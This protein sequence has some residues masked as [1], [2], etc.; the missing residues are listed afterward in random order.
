MIGTGFRHLPGVAT[1]KLDTVRCNGCR[2]CTEVCPHGVFEIENQ[3]AAIVDLDAC[4]E[5]GACAVNC[6]SGAIT[7]QSGVGCATAIIYG[8]LTGREPVCGPSDS[9]STCCG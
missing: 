5:C 6:E 2:I 9:G 7:V 3:K 8:A 4:M 1:L